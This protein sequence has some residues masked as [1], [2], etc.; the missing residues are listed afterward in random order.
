MFDEATS[1]LDN[2]TEGAVMSAI[3]A[4]NRQSTIIIIAHRLSTIQSCDRIIKLA[5]GS[6]TLDGPPNFVLKAQA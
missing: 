3:E 4:L 5:D 1:A 2:E 6:I